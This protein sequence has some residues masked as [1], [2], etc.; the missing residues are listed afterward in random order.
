MKRPQ[1]RRFLPIQRCKL[2]GP[3]YRPA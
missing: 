2:T 3:R 1:L